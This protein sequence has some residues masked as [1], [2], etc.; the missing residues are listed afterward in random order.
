M[1]L[2]QRLFHIV[3]TSSF[4]R[5]V[6]RKLVTR[7]DQSLAWHEQPADI[8]GHDLSE[9]G[10]MIRSPCSLGSPEDFQ[11]QPLMAVIPPKLNPG[12]APIRL[13][14]ISLISNLFQSSS[15]DAC[16]GSVM[17]VARNSYLIIAVDS[18]VFSSP[19]RG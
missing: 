1:G 17:I 10:R 11:S 5:R 7:A 19:T 9:A 14:P 2:K 15:L 3:I 6:E 16:T 4:T 13:S 8:A 12:L 18:R